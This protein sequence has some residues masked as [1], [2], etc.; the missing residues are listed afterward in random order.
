MKEHSNI[1]IF[2]S[3]RGCPHQCVYCDQCLI[4][5]DPGNP[6]E[7]EIHQAIEA[8][9]STQKEET[10]K[11]IAF[12]GGSFSAL[13]LEIQEFYLSIAQDYVGKHGIEGIRFSTRPDALSSEKMN[14]YN[15]F[16]L[17]AI[18]LGVQSLDPKVL[19]ASKRGHGLIDVIRAANL[20]AGSNL[21]LGMQM[22]IGLPED[23]Y[24]SAIFTAEKMIA[25]RPDF[26][27]IYPTLV[28]RG[29]GLEQMM[30]KGSYY[31][32]SLEETIEVCADVL[33]LFTEAHIP[34]IRCGLYSEAPDFLDS[35]VAG[36]Y[37]P[38]LKSLVLSRMFYKKLAKL[39]GPLEIVLH[40]RDE[41]LLLG[42][43]KE[44]L[45]RLQKQGKTLHYTLDEKIK[46]YGFLHQD[47]YFS[48]Y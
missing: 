35:V 18:E 22:M 20:I 48:I 9:L 19:R 23:H 37:H 39:N 44:N 26:V 33:A 21:E 12:F 5:G 8:Y 41:S 2:L 46:R 3:H 40:P 30:E 36:P 27:R 42:N 13:P 6:S 38:A 7:E 10:R 45:L 31:P 43:K 24:D 32:W 4:T 15:N 11:E 25:L 17:S 16:T 1:P 29:T 34:V 28:L 14:L 47:R